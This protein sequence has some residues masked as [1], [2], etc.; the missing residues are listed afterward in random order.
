MKK[1]LGRGRVSGF[2]HAAGRELRNGRDER[3]LLLGWGLGNWL[4]CEGYMWLAYNLPRFDRPR[5]I[6][7][8]VEE[9]G[10]ESGK[11]ALAVIKATS[12]MIGID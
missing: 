4:L 11:D 8:V 9:L 1:A 7:A 12:V 5:R 6:E 10:L 3:V 2:L